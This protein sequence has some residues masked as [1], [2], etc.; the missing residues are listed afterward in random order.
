MIL[1]Q[2]WD[3]MI[4][5]Q[6]LS[7]IVI[8]KQDLNII[9]ITRQDLSNIVI[10]RQ[11]LSSIVITRQARH[12]LLEK[13]RPRILM[14]EAELAEDAVIINIVDDIIINAHHVKSTV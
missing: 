8:T 10:T 12:D 7:C 5:R 3:L 6:N 2:H 1:V 4:T 11:D 14:T 9:V 13:Y